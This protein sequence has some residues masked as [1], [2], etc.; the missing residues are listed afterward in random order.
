MPWGPSHA[1][2]WRPLFTHSYP[3]CSPKDGQCKCLPN[4]VSRQCNEPAPG[5]FFL[6]LDYYIYEAEHAKP[7]S[8]SAPLV[9][10]WLFRW[11]AG[12]G[13]MQHWPRS[14]GWGEK[15]LL[16]EQLERLFSRRYRA[17]PLP[18]LSPACSSQT[19][20]SP[21]C[22]GQLLKHGVTCRAVLTAPQVWAGLVSIREINLII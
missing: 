6:P 19:W 20:L 15:P 18:V 16:G 11:C 3:R 21:N 17:R 10:S 1:A 4:I 7:L 12:W 5:Y 13:S 8:G 2:L 14:Q 22:G 9:C